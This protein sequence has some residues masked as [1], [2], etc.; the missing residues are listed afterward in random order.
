MKKIAIL[1]SAIAFAVGGAQVAVAQDADTPET[2]EETSNGAVVTRDNITEQAVDENGD[3][4]PV[5]DGDGNP[6]LDDDGNPVYETVTVGF[7]QTVETPSGHRHTITKE[8]GSRAIVTHEFA[9]RPERAARA[10]RPARAERPE[11]PERPE[12][13]ERP[14]RPEKPDRPERP[15]RPG[16]N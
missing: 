16:R 8:D 5:L 2:G 12:K 3:P 10:D 14:E 13:P 4:I 11:R 1:G 6:V 15:E 7:V 9:D